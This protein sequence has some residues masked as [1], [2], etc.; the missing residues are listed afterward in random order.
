MR[1]LT[2]FLTIACALL[3]SGCEKY[4]LDRQMKELCAK[5]GGVKVYETVT[6]PKEMFDRTGR[7][8]TGNLM[9]IRDG[10][11]IQNVG[12]AYVIE[13]VTETIDAGN[14]SSGVISEGRLLRFV[15]NIRRS[16]DNKL[17]GTEVSYGRTGG[18]ITFGHPG[19]N[20]CPKPRSTPGIIY[21]VFKQGE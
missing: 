12:S 4:A 5:D 19:Q 11:T 13:H 2:V 20:Y 14:P 7:P 9:R 21:A 10:L 1:R 6:L 18:G 3:A 17:L 15:T 16:L 8:I